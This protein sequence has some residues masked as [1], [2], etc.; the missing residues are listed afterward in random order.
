MS[1]LV[2]YTSPSPH[3]HSPFVSLLQSCGERRGYFH[4]ALSRHFWHQHGHNCGARVHRVL[5]RVLAQQQDPTG[6]PLQPHLLC[7]MPGE[8]VQAEGCHL[9]RL[10]PSLPLDYLHQSQP[11]FARGPVGQHR[12]LGPDFRGADGE[13]EQFSGGFERPK[14]PVDPDHTVSTGFRTGV[15]FFW[16]F[17]FERS[18]DLREA[19][20]I[21]HTSVSL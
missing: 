18:F 16:I 4:W 8:N 12:N 10:L 3:P 2:C 11:D 14:V 7:P 9:H 5:P 21:N 15:Q 13:W 19:V 20:S 1:L 6:A 17:L